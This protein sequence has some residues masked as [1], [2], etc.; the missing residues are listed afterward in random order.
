MLSKVV[1]PV[2]LDGTPANIY[3]KKQELYTAKINSTYT[4]SVFWNQ[5]KLDEQF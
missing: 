4:N 2:A 1:D 5:H 3:Y